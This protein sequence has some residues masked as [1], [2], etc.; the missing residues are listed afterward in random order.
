[1]LSNIKSCTLIGIDGFLID[2]ETDI[3]KGMPTFITVGLPDA[4]V[5][6]SKDRI[7]SALKNSGYMLPAKRITV[8]LAPGNIKKEGTLYDA[9]IALGILLS[10]SQITQK[11][12]LDNTL[13]FGE[14]AL[15]GTIRGIDGTLPMT[16]EAK[17]R[18]ITRVIVPYENRAEACLVENIDIIAVKNLKELCGYISGE[19]LIAPLPPSAVQPGAGRFNLD[20]SDVK[21]HENAKRAMEVAAAGA[22]NMLMIG[23]PGS[24]KTMLARCFPSI[25][26]DM[27]KNESL[28]VTKIYSIAGLLKRDMPLITL[29]PYRSPHHTISDI[30]LTGGGRIPRPGEVSLAHLGVLFL[31]ELP[32]FQK[33]SLESLRQPIEDKIVTIS[34]V[35]ATITYPSSF[36]L[37]ASMNPCPC[38]YYGDESNKCRC[39]SSEIKRYLGKISGPLLDRIDIHIEVPSTSY[40]KLKDRIKSESSENIKTR[41]N[42]ARRI[43]L[44]RYRGTDTLFNSSLSPRQIERYCRLGESEEKLM[45]KAFTSLNLSSRAYHRILKLA[46]TI[47]DLD[48]SEDIKTPHIAEAVQ[49][50]SLDR[51]YWM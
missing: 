44:E 4:S 51:K 45:K 9:P 7:A 39:T 6:E 48:A 3:V 23:P 43:Q 49:Y 20:Y 12:D 46:R 15:D 19:K 36:M 40:E 41:V 8:N 22:H 42:N 10:S 5:K 13:I 28:E 50:R 24:G 25:L 35:N 14:L 2:I 1:M 38:G 21:G 47:A 29:R 26:P 11:I 31:D 18:K 17:K 30:S 34:R 33:T 16:V 32:E 27:T 37:L